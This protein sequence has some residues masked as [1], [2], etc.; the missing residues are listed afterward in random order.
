MY[1]HI[2][3]GGTFDGLHK[4]HTYLL[5]KTFASGARVT[6]GLTSEAYIRRFKKGK[7]IT[8][9]SKRYQALTSWLRHQGV[10]ERT[11]IVPLDN[12]WGSTIIAQDIDAIAV[13][14]DNRTTADEINMLRHER[15]LPPLAIVEVELIPAEDQR[16]ISSTRMREGEI[17][18][19]GRLLLPDSLRPELQRPLGKILESSG[20]KQAVLKNRDNVVI[21][22]GDVTTETVFLCGVKPALAIIDLQVERKPYQPFESFKFPKEYTIV[23]VKSGPGYIAKAAIEAVEAWASGI[24]ERKRIVLVIDGEE[25]LLTLPVIV[26]APIGSIVYYGHPPS[27]GREG[28]VEVVVT[29]EKKTEVARLLTRFT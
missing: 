13:T 3:V 2:V 9:H 14:R 19:E 27:T 7:D 15:G 17:D 12:R 21:A 25:D 28:L 1:K 16:T 5:T 6:I 23:R 10:A 4:G 29:K 26:H 11:M 24:R 22:V 8:P 18:G 20:I